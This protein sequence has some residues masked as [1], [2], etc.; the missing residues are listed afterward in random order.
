MNPELPRSGNGN[1]IHLEALAGSGWEAVESR[2]G[3]KSED[4]TLVER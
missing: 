4:M 3:P 2:L 1:E